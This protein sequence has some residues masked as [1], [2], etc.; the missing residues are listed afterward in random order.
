MGEGQLSGVVESHR[1]ASRIRTVE[2]FVSG[3]TEGQ[4]QVAEAG[5]GSVRIE[6]P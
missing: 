3:D 1:A 4:R 2:A 5:S 6:K